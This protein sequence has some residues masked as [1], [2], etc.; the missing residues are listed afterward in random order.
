PNPLWRLRDARIP[1]LCVIAPLHAVVRGEGESAAVL[2]VCDCGEAGTPEALGWAGD[3]CGPCSDRRAEGGGTAGRLAV[4]AHNASVRGLAFD[5]DNCIL[6][7]GR[8]GGLHRFD[9]QSGDASMRVSPG[10]RGGTGVVALMGDRAAV[11][12]YREVVC[13]DLQTGEECWTASCPGEA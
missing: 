1:A 10:D 7:V 3:C 5:E 9:P 12:F 6:S 11:A 4:R 8:D 13:W 2:V